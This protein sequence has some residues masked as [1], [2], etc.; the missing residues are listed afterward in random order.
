M[1]SRICQLVRRGVRRSAAEGSS[2]DAVQRVWSNLD[3]RS[4]AVFFLCTFKGRRRTG[5]NNSVFS[6]IRTLTTRHCPHSPAA[7]RAAVRRAAIDRCLLLAGPTAANLQQRI[8]CCG[9]DAKTDARLAGSA[10][11]RT[12]RRRTLTDFQQAYSRLHFTYRLQ[13]CAGQRR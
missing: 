9:A 7:R 11:R 2:S 1:S 13:Q 4:R 12:R 5:V 10:S 6:F 8:F 3:R